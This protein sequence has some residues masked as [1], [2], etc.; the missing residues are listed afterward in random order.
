MQRR[1]FVIATGSLLA[2]T[3]MVSA[4][5]PAPVLAAIPAGLRLLNSAAFSALLNQSFNVYENR[6]GVGMQLIE[7]RNEKSAPGAEQFT[8]VFSASAG[9]TLASGTYDVEQDAIGL[10]PMYLQKAGQN[11]QGQ[12]YLAHFNLLA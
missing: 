9:T 7:V 3:G 8:L 12:L 6:H 2:A 1:E 11:P 4:A 5:A 10:T